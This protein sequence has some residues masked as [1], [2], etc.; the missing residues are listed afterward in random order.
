MKAEKPAEGI[1]K[2]H[3][4]GYSKWYKVSCGCG[5]PDHE[6]TFEV[7]ADDCGVNV[8]TYVTAKTDYWTETVKPNIGIDNE[9]AEEFDSAWKSIFNSLVRKV[10]LTWNIW[11]HGYVKY[12][13]TI[14][15]TQQQALNYAET[16][17]SAV[18]DVAEFRKQ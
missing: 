4:W 16:L 9:W 10:K 13:T 15:M 12:E 14:A 11:V 7:E 1:L 8:N 17:K 6:V 5:Q 3:D 18:K 2:T